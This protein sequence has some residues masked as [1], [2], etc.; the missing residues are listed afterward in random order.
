[1]EVNIYSIDD[2]DLRRVSSYVLAAKQAAGTWRDE[3]TLDHVEN[4]MSRTFAN[5]NDIVLLAEDSGEILGCAI[6][7][8]SED[9]GAEINPWFMG[10][11]PVVGPDLD[12][13]EVSS[14]LIVRAIVQARSAGINRLE[15]TFPREKHSDATK[16]LLNDSGFSLIEQIVHMRGSLSVLVNEVPTLPESIRSKPL[17][18]VNREDLFEC[19]TEAFLEGKDRSI[20]SKN[21][22]ERKA[23]FE[24]SFDFAEDLV[25]EASV[26]ILQ[27]S[28]LVA[29]S[30]LRPTHGE[31]NGHLWEMGV[32]PEF[33]G[34]GLAKHLLAYG[35]QQLA[36][37]GFETMSLNVDVANTPAHRLYGAF[38]LQEDWSLV[39]YGWRNGR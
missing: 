27:D 30:L 29:F 11:L 19:W 25:E 18:E 2:I 35:A 5:S 26:A 9:D 24:E 8:L 7:H 15:L 37:L 10:G 13:L 22:K 14:H 28:K 12:E 6:L 23:F 38:G 1:M 32:H 36:N 3:T 39:S 17:T 16:S 20:L 4:T 34:M 33:R 21:D 31:K